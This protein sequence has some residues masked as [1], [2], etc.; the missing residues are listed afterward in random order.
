[1]SQTFEPNCFYQGHI[2]EDDMEAMEN[3]FAALRSNFSGSTPPPNPVPYQMW[4]DTGN[5]V[6]R[7]RNN[8]NSA[9]LGVFHGTTACKMWVYRDSAM[10][11]YAIDSGVTD[12]VV[13]LKGG[14]TYTTGAAT[15]GTWTVSFDHLHQWYQSNQPGAVDHVWDTNIDAVSLSI[16]SSINSGY[17][18]NLTIVSSGLD[19]YYTEE[20]T[21]STTWRIA[22]AVGTLQY[23]DI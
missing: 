21:F 3:N 6:L 11:G 23:L 14:S 9:W 10:D 2:A 1:M 19:D 16:N 8:A 5:Y 17:Y 13:A 22:G 20:E 18:N 12:R 15:A 4:G 7:M